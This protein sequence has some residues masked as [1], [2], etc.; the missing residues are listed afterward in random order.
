MPAS[1]SWPNFWKPAK[2]NLLEIYSLRCLENCFLGD[3]PLEALPYK[4]TV[5]IQP[6][7]NTSML[8]HN[9]HD[10]PEGRLLCSL[11]KDKIIRVVCGV[12][13]PDPRAVR[14]RK[15]PGVCGGRWDTA[16]LFQLGWDY[17]N[18]ADGDRAGP[19]SISQWTLPNH[20][21]D[22]SM[23]LCGVLLWA[24]FC[25][26]VP[27][28][29]CSVWPWIWWRFASVSQH[30]GAGS[31][32]LELVTLDQ[33]PKRCQSKP[34]VSRCFRIARSKAL[35]NPQTVRSLWLG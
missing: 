4:I 27:S 7:L 9:G 31:Y 29:L 1:S 16:G 8:S 23:A 24:S 2:W 10:C 14:A 30:L 5:R 12:L 19:A 3:S 26:Q 32:P 34:L 35:E 6:H 33:L 15:A 25:Q 21:V 18:P 28:Q 17:C 20:M 22:G 13:Q 11:W